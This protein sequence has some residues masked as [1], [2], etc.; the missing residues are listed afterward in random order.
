VGIVPLARPGSVLTR[1]KAN[2]RAALAV[3]DRLDAELAGPRGLMLDAAGMMRAARSLA[4]FRPDRLVL[5]QLAFTLP[6]PSVRLARA[7]GAPV[8]LWGFAG[9]EE[10]GPSESLRAVDATAQAMAAAGIS[11]RSLCLDADDPQA[12]DIVSSML[13]SSAEEVLA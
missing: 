11:C 5:L 8:L 9:L 7:V 3:L 4:S 10:G 13:L 2:R 1:A 6:S 12:A